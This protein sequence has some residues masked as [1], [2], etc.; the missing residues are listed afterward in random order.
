ML[1]DKISVFFKLG[2]CF[3][4]K[5]DNY[6]NKIE[7][8]K[9]IFLHFFKWYLTFVQCMCYISSVLK[10]VSATFSSRLITTLWRKL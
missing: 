7:I 1:I 4:L 5:I 10:N 2:E 6:V 9:K 8:L 3:Y